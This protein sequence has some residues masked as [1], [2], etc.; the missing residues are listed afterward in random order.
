MKTYT[1]DLDSLWSENVYIDKIADDGNWI[2]FT[3][4]Y[5]HKEDSHHLLKTD[6]KK[7]IKLPKS[8]KADFSP[9][10]KWFA[11]KSEDNVL[12]LIDL[13][14]DFKKIWLHVHNFEFSSDGKYLNTLTRDSTLLFHLNVFDLNNWNFDTFPGVKE[15]IC[16]QEY[17]LLFLSETNDSTQSLIVFN[18]VNKQK[19]ILYESIGKEIR[20]VDWTPASESIVFMEKDKDSNQIVH[21]N[22]KGEVKKLKDYDLNTFYPNYKIHAKNAFHSGAS[23]D[24]VFFYRQPMEDGVAKGKKVENWNTTDSVIYPR[25]Q[26]YK[27]QTEDSLLTLWN[28]KENKIHEVSTREKPSIILNPHLDFC[29]VYNELIYEPMYKEYPYVDIY[30]K[31]IDSGKELLISDKVYNHPLNISISPKGNYV[32]FFRD[33]Q[34]WV[35]DVK[36]QKTI[37]VN[38]SNLTDFLENEKP[39]KVG[40]TPFETV[41]WVSDGNSILI[42][43]EYDVWKFD[44]P[45]NNLSRLTQG[46]EQNKKYRVARDYYSNTKKYLYFFLNAY[47]FMLPNEEI[48]IEIT[49]DDDSKSYELFNGKTSLKIAEGE[50]STSE[51]R[52]VNHHYFYK[53]QKYNAP[54]S[55]HYRNLKS[56]NSTLLY[57]SNEDLLHYDLGYSKKIQYP[58]KNCDTLGGAL[59]YPSNFNPRKKYPLVVFIYEKASENI[60]NFNSPIFPGYTGFNPLKYSLNGYFVLL[61]DIKYEI[62]NPGN[63]ALDAVVNSVDATSKVA[64]IDHKKIGLYG[65][66]FGGYEAAFIATQTDKFTAIVAG[67]APTD[68]SSWYHSVG[69]DWNKPE[70]WRF[71]SG[72]FR[73]GDSFYKVK[74]KYLENSPIEHIG[75]LNT[76]LLLWAGKKDLQVHWVQSVSFFLS[77]MRL[78]KEGKLLLYEDYHALTDKENQLHLSKEIFNW[79]NFYLK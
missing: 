35:W 57:Q 22:R 18:P 47:S 48:V 11:S 64:P 33:S 5:W 65:H 71:E 58:T 55:I 25:R 68:F 20:N 16:L 1:S 70:M 56:P 24:Y 49:K 41:F 7:H 28:L 54:P 73:M 52:G 42:S 2:T 69:W 63:S 8:S 23:E 43:D 67:S 9:D 78:K 60:H 62:G 75:K 38:S 51:I 6:H 40:L 13:N 15:F 4:D 27:N 14:S 44:I 59:L 50:K 19:K 61:P 76:P 21:I 37:S 53:T 45:K 36:R 10:H 30:I 74:E 66:S 32:A 31:M 17:E 79:F 77:M 34:W 72:Q 3:E 12:T 39:N 46:K 29:L 26:A